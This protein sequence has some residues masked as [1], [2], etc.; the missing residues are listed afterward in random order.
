ML[1]KVAKNIQYV[2]LV[3][4]VDRQEVGGFEETQLSAAEEFQKKTG[5]GVEPIVTIS[6]IIEH[7]WDHKNKIS[8][9]SLNE[10][11][12]LESYITEYGTEEARREL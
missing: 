4:A 11:S 5:M 3:I 6:E 2:G 9:I 12:R 8:Q 10:K 1:N 7:L